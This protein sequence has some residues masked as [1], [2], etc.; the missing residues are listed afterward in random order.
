MIDGKLAT[1]PEEISNGVELDMERVKNTL[2]DTQKASTLLASIFE[3]EEPEA[4]EVGVTE[5]EIDVDGNQ[6][7]SGLDFIHAQL[8]TELLGRSKWP[9]DDFIRLA[10]SLN[11]L[12]D[13]AMEVINEWAFEKFDEP[14]LEDGEPI[15]VYSDLLDGV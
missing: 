12:P 2:V 9:R 13:G 10:E 14:I 5:E 4:L 6:R 3:D 15:E 8:L 7:F 1:S 11:L